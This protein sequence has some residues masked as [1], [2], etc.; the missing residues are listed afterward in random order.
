MTRRWL[1]ILL[2]VLAPSAWAENGNPAPFRIGLFPYL[3]PLTLIAAHQPLARYLEQR[4][5][6][7]VELMTAPDFRTFIERTDAGA[8]D[9]VL[10]APHL[11]RLA[12]QNGNYKPVAIYDQKLRALLVVAADSRRVSIHDLRGATIA[13]P[14]PLA[15]VGALAREMLAA[16]GLGS[17]D[18]RWFLAHSHNGAALAVASGRAD[19]AVVGSNPFARLPEELRSNLR[20]LTTS[21]AI[22]NEAWLVN[23]RLS[24]DRQ[25]AFQAALLS[26]SATPAGQ[27][28]LRINNLEGLHPLRNDELKAMDAYTAQVRDQ[29]GRPR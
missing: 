2:M 14:D 16:A 21:E 13:E 28:Y 26:F 5:Q 15:I 6:Q 4:L 9:A 11:A 24:Q 27:H 22:P 1:L 10:T 18:V 7:P 29:L 23:A 25:R 3:S 20:I 12:E 17:K 19:A 8:Y